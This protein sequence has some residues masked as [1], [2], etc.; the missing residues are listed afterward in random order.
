MK[1]KT[2][3]AWCALATAAWGGGCSD[4]PGAGGANAPQSGPVVETIE[5]EA[6]SDGGHKVELLDSKGDGKADIKTVVDGSGRPI[7]RVTDINHDGKA[8]LYEYFDGSGAIR[9]READYDENGIIDSVEIYEGGKLVKREYDTTGQH[10]VDT[11]D[12]FDKVS[13]KRVRRERDTTNDGKVDQ[14]WT[15]DGDKITIAVDRNG[16]GQPDPGATLV[17]EDKNVPAKDAKTAP[18]PPAASPAAPEGPPPPESPIDSA[19]QKSQP[20][21]SGSSS[22]P[23][24]P[25]SSPPASSPSGGGKK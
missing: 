5:H 15:W 12:Y 23:S 11:W 9:R 24:S 1:L 20:A 14:W 16:D 19:V 25:L 6:C 21:A 4:G 8:D 22:K 13:G 18:P 2:S 17:L 7:C 3:L 10:R